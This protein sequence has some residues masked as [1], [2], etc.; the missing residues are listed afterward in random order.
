MYCTQCGSKIDENSKFCAYCGAST[1]IDDE[2]AYTPVT[3]VQPIP[4][5]SVAPTGIQEAIHVENTRPQKEK[6]RRIII[7]LL[8]ILSLLIAGIGGVSYYFLS[9][10]P[11]DYDTLRKELSSSKRYA[12]YHIK[13]VNS[14]V[15]D[16]PHVK[17]Y[18]SLTDDEGNALEI[19]SPTAA[20]RE[21][22]GHGRDIERMIRKVERIKD[23]QGVNY[24]I[25]LDKSYSMTD[26]MQIMKSTMSDFVGGL[27][28]HAGDK[29]EIVS[30]DTY[31][32]YMATF[33]SQRERLLNGIDNMTPYGDTALYDALYTG[34]NNAA[35]RSGFNCVIAF[36]DG[37][38]NQ[39]NHTADDVIELAKQ[40]GIPIYLIG[41]SDADT[42]M[43]ETIS[44][45][46]K[47][48]FW[49]IDSINDMQ[50]I[51]KRIKFN[52]ENVYCLEYDSDASSNPYED[53]IISA[54]LADSKDHT[55]GSIGDGLDL[56]P[57]KKKKHVKASSQLV[58]HKEDATWTQAN[59]SC[60]ADGGHLATL[61]RKSKEKKIIDLAEKNEVRYVWIG[62]YTSQ[63]D[64]GD[65]YAH[66]VTGE[67]MTYKNWLPGEPSRN[68]KDGEP[69]F[70]MMLWNIQDHWSWND[71]RNDVFSTPLLHK[72]FSGKTGYVCE[73]NK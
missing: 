28:Y 48:Y 67:P 66:W 37:E 58:L 14:D 21:K 45:E 15:S 36:T 30:F 62:G 46:S 38:D 32:M 22:I 26:S 19:N 16:Y 3:Y 56:K 69:E 53:R 44:S 29:A 6:K 1:N 34:V 40:K 24:E 54:L 20:I 61:S 73:V 31:L 13:I 72:T 59:S 63:R 11:I 49:N 42:S 35:D 8:V 41:T 71:Q 12:D 68:D 70:Y 23:K 5:Q 17:L 7:V 27:N 55:V 50:D 18:F 9:H 10:K 51:M 4:V 52:Q 57:V 65:V 47:G 33:T 39:S 64:D 2:Q 60:I 25:L 43:L